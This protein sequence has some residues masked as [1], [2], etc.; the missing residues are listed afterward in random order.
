LPVVLPDDEAEEADEEAAVV[1]ITVDRDAPCAARGDVEVAVGE[2]VAGQA[3]HLR[4][5]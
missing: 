1:V 5:T 3:R 4:A 2:D